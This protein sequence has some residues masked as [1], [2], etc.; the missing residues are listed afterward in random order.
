MNRRLFVVVWLLAMAGA[1]AVLPYTLTTQAEVLREATS[2]V[3]LSTL[4]LLSLLQSGVLL[5]LMTAGGLILA[6]RVG[7]GAP[8][9]T[10]LTTRQSLPS[11]WRRLLLVAALSGAAVALAIFFLD[12]FLF[13]PLLAQQGIVLPAPMQAPAWQRF[14]AAF[15]GG[16]TEEVIMRLFLMT[17]LVWLGARLSRTVSGP[18]SPAILWGAIILAATL[19]GLGHLPATA[20]LGLPLTPL[21]ITRAL[22]LNGVAGVAFGWFYWRHGLESAMGAHFVADIFILLLLPPLL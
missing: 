7:L 19:F 15:Y 8:W 2:T 20:G 9:L 11:G 16:I 6:Q 10:A 1:I 5:A 14:L 3:P 21:V 4:L 18:P 17:L 13:I 12:R 22:L